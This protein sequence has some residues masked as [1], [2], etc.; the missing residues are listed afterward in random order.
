MKQYRE[1]T[2]QEL[3]D[4]HNK[5]GK[6]WADRSLSIVAIASVLQFCSIG[7]MLLS[8]YLLDILFS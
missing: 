6:Y 4:W 1:A 5:E 3:E 7:F 8:F 2:P